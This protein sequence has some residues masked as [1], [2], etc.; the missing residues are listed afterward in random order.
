MTTEKAA[1]LPIPPRIQFKHM[2]TTWKAINDQ[3]PKYIQ[4][5]SQWKPQ[6]NLILRSRGKVLLSEPIS[7]NKNMF[8]DRGASFV[9][10]KL[11]NSHTDSARNAITLD[12][13]K[14]NLKTHLFQ[15]F[16]QS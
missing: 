7:Q 9:A 8:E 13:I 4:L 12:S 16:Y 11:W 5:L 10:P 1:L 2:A 15:K 14:K 3:A 6:L